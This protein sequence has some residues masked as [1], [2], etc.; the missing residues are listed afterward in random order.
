MTNSTSHIMMIRPAA[1]QVNHQTADSNAFQQ[2]PGSLSEEEIVAKSIGQFDDMVGLL[3]SKG[4]DV[5]VIQDTAEPPKPD[6]VF[7][8]N[9]ISMHADGR[10]F[11]YPM[12][13]P[14]RRIERRGDIVELLQDH[15]KVSEVIDWSD[16]EEEDKILEGTGSVVFDHPNKVMYACRSARTNDKLFHKL[17]LEIGYQPILFDAVDSQ[18]MEIYHTNVLMAIGTGYAVVAL[19]TLRDDAQR[20]EVKTMLEKTGLQIIDI[21]PEQLEH[22]AGNMLEVKSLTG[23][24]YLVMSNQAYLSLLPD[25]IEAINKYA[26]ILHPNLETIEHI[27]GGSARCMMAEIY[28]PAKK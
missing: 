25:Q 4:I 6:A 26:E 7:P 22:F 1:F 23:Q 12:Y 10:I 27:G 13:T 11:L 2:L 17:A 3:R 21:S 15:F 28:L 5:T 18:G 14:N 20:K 16:N 8:N 19:Y 9:W 24:L